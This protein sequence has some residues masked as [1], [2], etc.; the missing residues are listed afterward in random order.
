[1]WRVR[2]QTRQ[3]FYSIILD[4]K[5]LGRTRKRAGV[6]R[7]IGRVLSGLPALDDDDMS[8]C[9]SDLK[10]DSASQFLFLANVLQM[11]L[12]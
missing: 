8:Q 6:S 5:F 1:M 10:T 11:M 3:P 2:R 7:L 4:A 9:T 12:A